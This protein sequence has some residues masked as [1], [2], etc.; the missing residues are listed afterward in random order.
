M[1][2]SDP[3]ARMWSDALDMVM[4]AERIHRQM[5]A[6]RASQ[7]RA[8]AWEPPIDVLET[9]EEV[10]V[11]AALPGVDPAE[12]KAVIHNGALVISGR[13]QMPPEMQTA[14]IHRMELP[15]G[16]FERS[17]PLPPGAYDRVS[18]AVVNGCLVVRLA[19]AR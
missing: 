11:W 6:P 15:Q 16:Y 4:R 2:S 7:Q 8:P 10:I 12:I 17:A 3:R 9:A 14:A 1:N 13:R 5:F 19:K 18:H